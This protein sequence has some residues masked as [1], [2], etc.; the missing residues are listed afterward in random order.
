MSP[1][2]WST[3]ALA[4]LAAIGEHLAE[5]DQ[6]LAVRVIEAVQQSVTRLADHPRSGSPLDM[7]SARKISVP[8]FRYVVIYELRDQVVVIS[9]VWHMSQN[10][11]S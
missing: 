1:L 11:L 6:E 4:D 3:L 7:H 10:W 2:Q 9:R 5:Q 8:R